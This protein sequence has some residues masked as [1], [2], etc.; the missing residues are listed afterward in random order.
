MRFW[1]RCSRS[2]RMTGSLRLRCRLAR[3]PEP[4][5]APSPRC[6]PP[7]RVPA[8]PPPELSPSPASSE[9]MA[10]SG[11][12]SRTPAGSAGLSVTCAHRRVLVTQ[13]RGRE[14]HT[15]ASWA[16]TCALYDVKRLPVA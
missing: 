6:P 5:P 8:P 11:P 12:D 15:S 4:L 14:G 16:T 2:S 7:Y 10:S 3:P 1:A 13:G 9:E